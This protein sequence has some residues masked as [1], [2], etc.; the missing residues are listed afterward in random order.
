[1]AHAQ[2]PDFVFRAKLTSPFKSARASVQSTTGS[3]GVRISC[4]NVGYTTLRG[5]VKS[6]GYPF[7][8]PVSPSLPLPCVTVCHHISTGIEQFSREFQ[9]STAICMMSALLCVRAGITT[10]CCLIARSSSGLNIIGLVF[11]RGPVRISAQELIVLTIYVSYFAVNLS[12][13]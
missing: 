5:S 11:R 12:K 1:M 2:K 7:Q 10:L 9:T 3:L 8:S 13:V 4:S 6:T